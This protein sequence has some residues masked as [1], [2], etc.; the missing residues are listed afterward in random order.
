MKK[1]ACLM[2]LLPVFFSGCI[3]TSVHP[4]YTD[5]DVVFV[6]ELLGTWAEENSE[7]TYAFSAH[8]PRSY[9]LTY[10]DD[11]GR[12][13]E[14]V[15]HLLK[16]DGV[17]FLDMFPTEQN[18]DMNEF[19]KLHFLHVHTFFLVEQI[20]PRLR[21]RPMSMNW[22][23]KLLEQ[24]PGAVRHEMVGGDVVLTAATEELQ[25]FLLRHVRTEAAFDDPSDMIRR[26]AVN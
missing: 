1:I 3:P 23:R 2:L 24:N 26:G 15:A 13:G 7:E 18:G 12:T 25:R 22:L 10:T 11:E 8:D 14:F 19:Y 9:R 20:E 5:K 6:P 17:L 4:V 16:I 21:M